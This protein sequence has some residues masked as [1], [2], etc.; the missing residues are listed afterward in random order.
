MATFPEVFSGTVE[1]T[2]KVTGNGEGFG[3]SA[4][5]SSRR[6]AEVTRNRTGEVTWK[7]L[8]E[9]LEKTMADAKFDAQATL[10]HTE[11][12]MRRNDEIKSA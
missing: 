5:Y 2:I 1:I 8:A 4:Y 9:A 11:E 10:E 7:E 12:L 3:G 6:L